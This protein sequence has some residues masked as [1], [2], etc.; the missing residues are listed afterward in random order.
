[1]NYK[2]TDYDNFDELMDCDSRT[3]NLLLDELGLNESDIGK[4]PWM[5]E[6]LIVYPN[7]E[8]YAIYELIDGWY[9][10]HNLGGSFNGA[11]N[12]LEYID[13]ADF[14][15]DLINIGDTTICRELPNCKVVTTSYGW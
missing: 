8:E 9:Q 11:P 12:P 3:A 1:M 15:A 13:L 5:N 14:G 7:V 10:N 4:E 2:Y 6:Q